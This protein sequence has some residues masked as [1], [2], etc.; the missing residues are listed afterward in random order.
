MQLKRFGA[1]L[2]CLLG[3]FAAFSIVACGGGSGGGGAVVG[4]AGQGSG[5]PPA[6]T[7]SGVAATGAPIYGAVTLKDAHGLQLGPISTDTDGGFT[8]DVTGLTPPF[9]LKAEWVSDSQS[10]VLYSVGTGPGQANINPFSN[11]T[12]LFAIGSDPSSIF[13]SM[14]TASPRLTADAVGAALATV[15]TVLAPLL[16]KYGITNFDPIGGSYVADPTNPLDTMLDLVTVQA[17][18][19]GALTIK[20]ATSVVLQ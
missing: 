9:M 17:D 15:R 20:N 19:G 11:L 6:Q 7:V 5:Q 14:A 3:V 2:P 8:F 12:L 13:E 10:Y 18:S 4:G 16:V 1:C